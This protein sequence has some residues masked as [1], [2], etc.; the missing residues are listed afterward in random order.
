M[1]YPGYETG[2]IRLLEG[3]WFPFK[4]HNL[5]QLQDDEWYYVLQDI[6]GMKH[7]MPAENYKHY[8]FNP[9]DE[10]LCKIDRI[11]CTG[12]IFLEP[13][14]PHYKEGEIYYFDVISLSDQGNEKVL[15]VREILGNSIEVPVYKNMN[16][17]LKEVKKI[18]CI[19]K[20]ITKGKPILDI[21]SDYC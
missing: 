11:N 12:R 19:V 20:T 5:V 14:H 18:R 9:G 15:I 4:I 13:N 16:T 1:H 21:D 8:G 2:E 6:N 7:F 17:D 3:K 10:I